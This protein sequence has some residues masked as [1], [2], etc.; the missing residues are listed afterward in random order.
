MTVAVIAIL[1]LLVIPYWGL[2]GYPLA[3]WTAG[4]FRQNQGFSRL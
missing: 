3:R 2:V 4:A 1:L